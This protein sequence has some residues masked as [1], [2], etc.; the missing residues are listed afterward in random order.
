[1]QMQDGKLPQ[2][3]RFDKESTASVETQNGKCLGCHE[4]DAGFAWHGGAHDDHRV[5]CAGCHQVHAASDAV[6]RTSTQPGK[7]YE[8]HAFRQER[9]AEGIRASTARGEDGLYRLPQPA[10]SDD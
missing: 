2:V 4:G 6:L 10:W 1:M 5:T 7:C 8:C 3:I 9:F